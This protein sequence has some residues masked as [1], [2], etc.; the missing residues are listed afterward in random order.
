MALQ[1]KTPRQAQLIVA[2]VRKVMQTGE[3]EHL[4]KQ[5]YDFLNLSSGFI[6]HYNLFGFR[7]YYSDVE[8][9]R[10]DILIHQM[11]NQWRNFTAHDKDYDYMMQKKLIYNNLCDVC[12]ALYAL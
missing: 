2:S 8:N 9:L 4:T 7:D 12:E 3:I 10:R 5:A 6:A 1:L 11:R